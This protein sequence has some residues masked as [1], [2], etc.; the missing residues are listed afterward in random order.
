MVTTVTARAHATRASTCQETSTT[1]LHRISDGFAISNTH[2]FSALAN[3]L[4]V[5]LRVAPSSVLV[6]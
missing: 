5:I 3:T 1:S 4:A 2:H 6:I